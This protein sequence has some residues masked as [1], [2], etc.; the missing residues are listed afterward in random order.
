[1]AAATSATIRQSALASP[2]ASYVNGIVMV[3]D[4]GAVVGTGLQPPKM[5]AGGAT[6]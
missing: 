4:G 1:M 2:G 3:A 5:Q 6:A